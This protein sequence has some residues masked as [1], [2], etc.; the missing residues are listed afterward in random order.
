MTKHEEMIWS[1][2]AAII[3]IAAVGLAAVLVIVAAP[4]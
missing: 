1:I 2:A 4:L 3:M